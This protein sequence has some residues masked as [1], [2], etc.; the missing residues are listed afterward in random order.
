N[1]ALE[2]DFDAV[3]W[4]EQLEA[5]P[6]V[7]LSDPLHQ[8]FKEVKRLLEHKY[9]HQAATHTTSYQSV[10]EIKRMFEEPHEGQ[11]A[12]I[13]ISQPRNQN[14]YSEDKLRRPTFL[15]ETTAPTSV[16]I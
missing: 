13:D 10:S 12:K 7:E 8:E 5:A 16:E 6:V 14:R 9:A 2:V 11:L 1:E 15:T 4:L 3:K